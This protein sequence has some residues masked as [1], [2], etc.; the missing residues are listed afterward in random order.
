MD[1][2][3]TRKLYAE[4]N[5]GVK[6]AVTFLARRNLSDHT[7][8]EIVTFFELLTVALIVNKDITRLD[9]ITIPLRKVI[10]QYGK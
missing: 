7:T 2:D 6:T 8:A 1:G 9:L 3:F 5:L 4:P 10:S